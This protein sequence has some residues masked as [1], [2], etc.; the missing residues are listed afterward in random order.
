MDTQLYEQSLRTLIEPKFRR[1]QHLVSKVAPQFPSS[2]ERE[3]LRFIRGFMGDFDKIMREYMPEFKH[4]LGALGPLQMDAAP[5][6]NDPI[7]NTPNAV[8]DEMERSWN[9]KLLS[10]DVR[11]RLERIANM[12]RKLTVAEWNRVMQ[13]TLG[14]SLL[15]D[16]YSGDF[17]GAE[18]QAWIARNV[19]LIVTQPKN[20]LVRMREIVNQSYMEGR[21]VEFIA[22]D[23]NEA[24][25]MGKR[26]AMLIARDQTAKLNAQ[27]TE[28]QHRD[29]GIDMYIWDTSRDQRV[30]KTHRRMHGLYCRYDNVNVYSKTGDPDSWTP[31]T[32]DMANIRGQ[33]VQA[34]DDYQCRCV[35]RAVFTLAGFTNVPVAAVDWQAVDQRL[36]DR[37]EA[38][39]K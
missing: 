31:K 28:R 21:R 26:H 19:D 16:Y 17:L 9:R 5:G 12:N 14:I 13:K 15:E 11:K 10:Y 39:K 34:G 30:R 32:P 27:I 24:Y 20:T 23:I 3:Y 37:M 35:K 4:A 2:V 6:P 29:A 36:I 25:G 22:R 7:S 18:I 1:K 38:M 33:Y 8:L